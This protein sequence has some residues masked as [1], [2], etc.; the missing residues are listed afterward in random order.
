MDVLVLNQSEVETL[1][2]ME[3]CIS[4]MA[5]ALS[6]LARGQV[7]QPVRTMVRPPDAAGILA[8]MPSFITHPDGPAFYGLKAICV[9]PGNPARGK[10]A[11]Q[12]AVLLYSGETGELLSLMNASAIT[13]IRTA[14]V[15]GVATQ[16]LAR[17]DASELAI[18]GAGVQARSHL[19][20]MHCVRRIKRARVAS[21]R[22]EHAEQ[23]ATELAPHYPFPI[24]P[25]PAGGGGGGGGLD[26]DRNDG[27]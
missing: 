14:A 15:S 21:R 26:R 17:S 20:A 2:P 3:E 12:G 22:I 9:F 11:H 18:I 10:D 4:V 27:H 25:V 5:D 24:E 13:A 7:H 23:V 1:L 6:A 16:L 8:L 19:Q